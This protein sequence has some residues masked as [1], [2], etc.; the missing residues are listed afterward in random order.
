[1]YSTF[2][3]FVFLLIKFELFFI[4]FYLDF[5]KNMDYRFNLILNLSLI[6]GIFLL[7]FMYVFFSFV[8][9]GFVFFLVG[10]FMNKGNMVLS[11]RI[12]IN[13]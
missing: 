12:L 2:V 11:L 8:G 5:N 6:N 9:D 1:M 7:Y 10:V 3:I 4:L 13:F